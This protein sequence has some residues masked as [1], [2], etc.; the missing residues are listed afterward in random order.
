VPA[1][2]FHAINLIKRGELENG[3]FNSLIHI[4]DELPHTK[5]DVHSQ[6]LNINMS[7]LNALKS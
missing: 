2:L 3:G 5:F 4:Y 1:L 7:V 6:F